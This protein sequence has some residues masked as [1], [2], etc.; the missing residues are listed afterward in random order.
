LHIIIMSIESK[1]QSVVKST[2]EW[3]RL[4]AHRMW[5]VESNI[6]SFVLGLCKSSLKGAPP[7]ENWRDLK[8]LKLNTIE[9]SVDWKLA[10]ASTIRFNVPSGNPLAEPIRVLNK[11]LGAAIVY[12]EEAGELGLDTPYDRLKRYVEHVAERSH[13]EHADGKIDSRDLT[14]DRKS[15]V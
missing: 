15:V 3:I 10:K 6:S 12:F 8:P 14:K 5:W 11:A 1:A 7:F 2:N 13:V 9:V 4:N